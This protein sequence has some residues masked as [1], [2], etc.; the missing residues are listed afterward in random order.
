MGEGCKEPSGLRSDN[1]AKCME[2]FLCSQP[3][4]NLEYFTRI[5]SYLAAAWRGGSVIISI[6]QTGKLRHWGVN[7]LAHGRYSSNLQRWGLNAGHYLRL[8]YWSFFLFVCFVSGFFLDFCC[9]PCVCVSFCFCLRES[10]CTPEQGRGKGE[11]FSG[12]HTQRGAQP[13]AR[14]HYLEIIA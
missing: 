12:L 10:T 6:K 11:K 14:S 1:K 13:L 9:S 4:R 7:W 8:T 3:R 2:P 5:N